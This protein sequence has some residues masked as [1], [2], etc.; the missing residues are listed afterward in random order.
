MNLNLNNLVKKSEFYPAIVGKLIDYTSSSGRDAMLVE[1][2]RTGDIVTIT[3]GKAPNDEVAAKRNTIETFKNPQSKKYM[4]K[5]A[6]FCFDNV[7]LIEKTGEC[8]FINDIY[9]GESDSA[10]T[11]AFLLARPLPNRRNSPYAHIEA[12]LIDKKKTVDTERDFVVSVIKSYSDILSYENAIG[13]KQCNK[14]II[15]LT[16]SPTTKPIPIY[17][18]DIQLEG[19]AYR[20]PKINEL[21]EQLLGNDVF[22]QVVSGFRSAT[23]SGMPLKINVIPGLRVFVT[24]KTV[25]GSKYQNALK[26]HSAVFN[27]N[28]DGE[29]KEEN[30]I[31]FRNTIVSFWNGTVNNIRSID[32]SDIVL[33]DYPESKA[34]GKFGEDKTKISSTRYSAA[35]AAEKAAE[36]FDS[37]D[38]NI[39]RSNTSSSKID[40][41]EGSNSNLNIANEPLNKSPVNLE[42]EDNE[43]NN[44]FVT[45][46][47]QDDISLDDFMGQLDDDPQNYDE[48]DYNVS[49]ENEDSKT[50]PFMNFN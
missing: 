46:S 38:E 47:N 14:P 7:K 33:N 49:D 19:G 10:R 3:Q 37:F 11:F 43:T 45:D 9:G 39:A 17:L 18:K 15:Y 23:E 8:I 2:L 21:K 32:Q 48:N 28:V 12:M 24:E 27:V 42:V 50:N 22:N 41:T 31:G 44:L 25:A 26:H 35:N 4:Q 6:V 5:G 34:V 29:L 13:V 36:A 40:K 1:D 30:E 20:R 16:D